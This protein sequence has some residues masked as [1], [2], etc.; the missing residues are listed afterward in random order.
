MQLNWQ[1]YH[2]QLSGQGFVD[3]S[4]T[5]SRALRCVQPSTSPNA[6]HFQ[7]LVHQL[8]QLHPTSSS[9]STSSIWP[10]H[11]Q[12]PV[13]FKSVKSPNLQVGLI[14]APPGRPLPQRSVP[15]R[16]GSPDLPAAFRPWPRPPGRRRRPGPAPRVSAARHRRA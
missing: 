1:L 2:H 6:S 14:P 13:S 15:S 4:G 10:L 12:L 8:E 9:S 3:L 5:F 11:L 7:P 16:P